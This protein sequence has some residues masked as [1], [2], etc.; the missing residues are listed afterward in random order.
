MSKDLA[1]MLLDRWDRLEGERGTWKSHWQ[2]LA[3]LTRP[4]RSEFT[5]TVTAGSKRT[6]Q[7]FDGTALQATENLAAGIYGMLSSPANEWFGI[8]SELDELNEIHEVQQ[9]SAIVSR[10]LRGVLAAGGDMFYNRIVDLYADLVSFG[11]SPFYSEERGAGAGFYYSTRHLAEGCI[12]Q[13]QFEEIDGL[14]RR[15]QFTARQAL[16]QWPGIGGAVAKAAEETPEQK[17]WFQHSVMPAK[18]LDLTLPGGRLFANIYIGVDDKAVLNDWRREGYFEFPYQVPR[19]STLSRDVYGD[20]PAMLV[21]PD[22]KMLN[23]M[24]KTTI[25]AAQKAVD[26]PILAVDEFAMRGIRATPG[27]PIY[28]GIDPTTG[29]RMLDPLLTNPQVN[30][31]LEMEDQRRQAIREGYYWSLLLMVQQPNMTAT[32]FLGRQEEKLRLMGPHLGRITTEFLS[33]FIDRMFMLLYRGGAFPAPPAVLRRYPGLR[34]A[35][36]SPLARAQK[37]SEANAIL[38]AIEG[39]TPLAS[40]QP[41]VWDN[42]DGDKTARRLAAGFA[43]PPDIMRDPKLVAAERAQRRQMQAMAAMAEPAQ[44]GADALKKA[45]E[46]VALGQQVMTGQGA[47]QRQAA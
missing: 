30:I 34:V 19:W 16:K 46:A 24:S 47:R 38:R 11:T 15:F 21:L 14:H 17:F 27:Q 37:A 28:G 20:S 42:F 44:R 41:E 29:R 23:Q 13:N 32:E 35:Y 6:S 5:G 18:E 22:V 39:V 33:P 9:W 1:K 4:L 2:E 7:I 25:I 43:V 12:E 40:Q 31:G 10:R 3:D 8:E 26:P 36:T 45:T